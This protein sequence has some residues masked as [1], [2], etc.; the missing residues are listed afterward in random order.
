MGPQRCLRGAALEALLA[1]AVKR[2]GVVLDLRPAG[3]G[4]ARHLARGQETRLRGGGISQIGT[5]WNVHQAIYSGLMFAN[6][7]TLAHFSVSSDMN[8]PNSAGEPA[9]TVR[10]TSAIF[11]FITGSL[12]A[13]F[14]SRLSLSIISAGAPLGAQTPVHE[15]T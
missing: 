9:R 8:L 11:P 3:A 14:T 5:L 1:S 2:V 7:T 13:A 10:P 4:G 12:S 15:L 6:L